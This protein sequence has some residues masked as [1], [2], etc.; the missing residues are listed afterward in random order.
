MR[1][2]QYLGDNRFFSVMPEGVVEDS[3]NGAISGNDPQ[4]HCGDHC[5][6]QQQRLRHYAQ[7]SGPPL[8]CRRGN[9]GFL[10]AQFN[11]AR[12]YARFSL[13]PR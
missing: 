11:S 1:L 6:Q 13:Y 10:L 9:S 12:G 3:G 7:V 4:G 5:D 8:R 2:D